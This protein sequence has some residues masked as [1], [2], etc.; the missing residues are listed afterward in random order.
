ME[1]REYLGFIAA[2][3]DRHAGMGTETQ[4]RIRRARDHIGAH[5]PAGII[6]RGGG[7]Q[8]TPTETPFI[9]FLDP[10]ETTSPGEGLYAVYL[11]AADLGT[12]YLSLNQ[13]IT[14]LTETMGTAAAR[15]KLS[16]DAATIRGGLGTEVSGLSD[17]IDLAS[18]GQRQRSYQ[19]GNI[20]A[21]AYPTSLLPSEDDLQ[22]DLNRMLALY[23]SAVATKRT[24]LQAA[25]GTIASPSV[26]QQSGEG[27][28]LKNFRPK[29]DSDYLSHIVGKQLTKSRRHE[30]VVRQFGE[31][32]ADRGF[33][34][35][36]AEHPRDLVLRKD[37]DEW[38]VEVKVLYQGNATEA[39]REALGQLFAYRHFHYPPDQPPQLVGVFS[40]PIGEAYVEFLES[41]GI[42][43]IWKGDDGWEGSPSAVGAGLV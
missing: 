9:A 35:S 12:V 28:P 19:A 16:E 8:T 36:T 26:L 32:V 11:L 14:S 33:S 2:N 23:Q 10:D 34:P 37:G 41:C 5:V 38:L 20:A 30:T 3:Y 6:V 42:A 7:G 22:Q 21:F 40:E 25:P 24:L 18:S 31:F 43:S 4:Q 1:L 15:S 29:D 13:G 39:V 17:S 27:D